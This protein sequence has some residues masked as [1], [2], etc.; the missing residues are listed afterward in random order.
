MLEFFSRNFK[1]I[2][3]QLSFAI[4]IKLIVY[5]L[6]HIPLMPILYFVLMTSKSMVIFPDG[7]NWRTWTPAMSSIR[8]LAIIAGL[9]ECLSLKYWEN[10]L[11]KI[12]YSFYQNNINSHNNKKIYFFCELTWNIQLPW[13]LLVKLFWCTRYKEKEL[14]K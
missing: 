7:T 12:W 10:S 5:I 4:N 8:R 13:Y 9:S 3:E 6:V 1:Y 2:I 14:H 11:C